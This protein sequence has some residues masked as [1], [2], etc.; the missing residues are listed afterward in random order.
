MSPFTDFS[1][2]FEGEIYS[3]PVGWYT[4]GLTTFQDMCML[5]TYA[6]WVFIFQKLVGYLS[7]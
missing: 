3:M 1:L 5:D 4:I 7:F 2:Y 6:T